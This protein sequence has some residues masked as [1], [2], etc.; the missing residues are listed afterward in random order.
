MYAKTDLTVWKATKTKVQQCIYSTFPFTT[1]VG[2]PRYIL[3][4]LFGRSQRPRITDRRKMDFKVHP[5]SPAAPDLQSPQSVFQMLYVIRLA[6]V[7]P[8][9]QLNI[10]I[11]PF[12]SSFFSDRWSGDGRFDFHI[13]VLDGA[14]TMR[15]IRMSSV[16]LGS[17]IQMAASKHSIELYVCPVESLDEKR[18]HP[19]WWRCMHS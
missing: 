11:Y 9:I 19:G 2:G 18:N 12:E 14:W 16:P 8:N 7:Y 3:S 10:R 15:I 4:I 5:L 6:Q 1:H 13:D 17:T